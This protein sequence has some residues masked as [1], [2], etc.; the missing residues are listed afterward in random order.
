MENSVENRNHESSNFFWF[1]ADPVKSEKNA[2]NEE[3][4]GCDVVVEVSHGF[5][6]HQT[7]P[8]INPLDFQVEKSNMLGSNCHKP[9]C[10]R[11][12]GRAFITCYKSLAHDAGIRELVYDRH[13][14]PARCGVWS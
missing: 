5:C 11:V 10:A 1:A 9:P 2:K 4:S 14:P 12:H 13:Q 8:A 3:V 7:T 6:P